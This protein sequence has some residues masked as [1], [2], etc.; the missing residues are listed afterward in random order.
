MFKPCEICGTNDWS[1]IY[2]GVIRAGAFGASVENCSVAVCSGCGIARLD[3]HVSISASAYE[4]DAYRIAM[5]Q[6]LET[7]DFFLTLIQ[8]RFTISQP[9][10]P[11]IFV[12]RSL[13]I[14]DVGPGVFLI[15][16]LGCPVS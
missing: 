16:S 6:G 5:A 15:I 11:C 10:A 9:S 2:E 14:L 12:I 3:E 7:E 4:S 8:L 13:L 1:S